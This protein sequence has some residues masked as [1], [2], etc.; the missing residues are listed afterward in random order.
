L[1]A[2]SRLFTGHLVIPRYA[3]ADRGMTAGLD[4]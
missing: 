2:F 3:I 1:S 4:A